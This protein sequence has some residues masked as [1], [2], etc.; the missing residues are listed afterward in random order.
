MKRY[1]YRIGIVVLCIGLVVCLAGCK[2]AD[3]VNED[4]YSTVQITTTLPEDS[5]QESIIKKYDAT[6][7]AKDVQYDLE[8][9]LDKYFNLTG[10]A[11]L[12]D[13]YNYGFDDLEKTHFVLRVDV[14][15]IDYWYIYC[16]RE[17]FDELFDDV[18]QDE[19][20]EIFAICHIPKSY[21]KQGQGTMAFLKSVAW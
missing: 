18:K 20:R 11:V 17:T 12:S 13:Y 1:F 5:P 14:G 15:S 8:N 3:V 2:D 16:N 7:T 4:V 21:Y 6:L 9:S 19:V 10:N